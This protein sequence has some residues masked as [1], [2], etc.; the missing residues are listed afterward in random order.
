MTVDF[1]ML[2]AAQFTPHVGQTFRFLSAEDRST[3]IE[4]ELT[5]VKE[6][7]D[8]TPR[9]AKRTSFSL[10]FEAFGQSDLWNGNFLLDHPTE[11]ALGPFFIVRTVP[12]NPERS[13][14]EIVLN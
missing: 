2:T 7:P 9:W 11:G 1:S 10:T 6:R 4:V 14:F 3:I 13:C 12:L 8:F 5:L